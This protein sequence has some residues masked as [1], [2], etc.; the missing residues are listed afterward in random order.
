MAMTKPSL[1]IIGHTYVTAFNRRKLTP[2]ADTFDITCVTWPL[3]DQMHFGSP[4]ADFED[5]GHEAGYELIRLPMSPRGAAPTS[6]FHQGLSRLL[7]QRS[8]DIVLADAEPWALV[9]WQAWMLTR[10]IQPRAL[11]GE[12]SWENVE[13]PGFKGRILA[14]V[15]RLAA[16][17]HDYSISGNAAGRGIFLRHGA[18]PDT[19]LVAAQI[20]VEEADF[21]PATA[22]EKKAL[23][24]EMA[25]PENGFL[26]GFCGR[27]TAAKGLRELL[28]A[29]ET[30]REKHPDRDVQLVVMGDGDMKGELT[31]HAARHR[32]LH[33]LPPRSHRGVASFMRCLDLFVLP[34]KP[35]HSSQGVWEEQFG[36]VLIEAMASGVATLGSNSGAIPEVIAMPEAAFPHS[37]SAALTRII[38]RW[39]LDDAGRGELSAAQRRRTL[40]HYTHEALARVWSSFLLQRLEAHH[41]RRTAHRQPLTAAHVVFP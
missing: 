34:S 30:L 37:D 1:L 31:S 9:R 24:R 36:H 21:C 26:C 29:I 41:S 3:D 16:R 12:F 18:R 28:T 7:H 13:R 23:R 39:M 40:E 17:S 22:A 14:L 27:L 15:Y 38:E 10:C 33:V 19:N 4:L 11:F 25:L 35:Q 8:F 6:Y 2:L 20:G 5:D 32:W